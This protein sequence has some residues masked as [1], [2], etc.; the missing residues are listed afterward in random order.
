[1]R[2]Y[3]EKNRSGD[4][5]LIESVGITF[6]LSAEVLFRIGDMLYHSAGVQGIVK[7][8]LEFVG[9]LCAIAFSFSAISCI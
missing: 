9:V 6:A 8:L 7:M 3:H 5:A 1:M 4:L 2:R